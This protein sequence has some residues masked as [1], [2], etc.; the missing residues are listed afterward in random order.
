MGFDAQ[1]EEGKTARGWG[2]EQGGKFWLCLLVLSG[3]ILFHGFTSGWSEICNLWRLLHGT[4]VLKSQECGFGFWV[5][6]L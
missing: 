6:S 2:W 4:C 3:P 1:E 5:L